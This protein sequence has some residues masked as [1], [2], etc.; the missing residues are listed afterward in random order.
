MRTLK[1]RSRG[2]HGLPALDVRGASAAQHG[3]FSDDYRQEA[4]RTTEPPPAK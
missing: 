4:R 2:R 1:C 3:P